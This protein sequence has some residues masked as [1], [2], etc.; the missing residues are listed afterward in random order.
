MSFQAYLD[1]I[2]TKTGKTPDDF[3]ALAKDKGFTADTKAKEIA[4]WL[5]TDFGLGHG[6]AMALVHVIK[7]GPQI[8]NKHIGTSGAHRDESNILQLDGLTKRDKSSWQK[9]KGRSP[10]QKIVAN[11]WFNGNAEEAVDFY[12]SVFPDGK[13]LTKTYYPK[14]TDE[15]LADFQQ[16]LAGKVLTVEFDL[17]GQL[18]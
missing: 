6:H 13:I 15:G 18:R 4:N 7:K 11:L 17:F 9:T 12:L 3:I 16:G 5:K 2:E 14:T 1:N 8:D 10:V